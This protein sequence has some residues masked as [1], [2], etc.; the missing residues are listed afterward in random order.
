MKDKREDLPNE[1]KLYY[2]QGLT[3]RYDKYYRLWGIHMHVLQLHPK[4]LQT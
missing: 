3:T 4:W 1:W 2:V